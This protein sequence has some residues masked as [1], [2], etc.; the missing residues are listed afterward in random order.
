M[1]D[2]G[3][4]GSAGR[5]PLARPVMGPAEVEAATRVLRSG[6]LVQGEEV[7]LFEQALGSW[8]GAP[9]AVAV[10]SGTA[11]L[12]LALLALG[13]GPGI[14]VIL[15]DFTF[16]ATGNAVFLCGAVPVLADVDPDTWTLTAEEL[17]RRITP[18]TR[19]VMQ[20]HLFGYPALDPDFL[21]AAEEARLSVLEDAAGAIGSHLGG[22]LCGTVGRAG[23]YSFHARKSLATGEGGAVVTADE[24]LAELTRRYRNHGQAFHEEGIRFELAGL[25]YRMMEVT[26]AIGR[27][28]L[29]DLGRSLE[30]RA[31]VAERYRSLLAGEPRVTLP[32]APA[33]GL[34]TYQAFVVRIAPPASRDRV[35]ASMARR[36]VE[37]TLGTYALHAQPLYRHR[38]GCREADYPVSWSLYRET[39]ALPFYPELTDA[40]LETVVSALRASLDEA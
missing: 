39:L 16:P 28:L 5:I 4:A 6:R 33:R 27:S 17:R 31:R 24:R 8:L 38:L 35:V 9:H 22:R 32:A 15:P 40:E 2:P 21:A 18:R 12:H 14:E 25:N 37:T 19:V 30:G 34:H 23:C 1:T 29:G 13:V 36:G 10:N 26:A 3:K 20:V 11:A 7:R